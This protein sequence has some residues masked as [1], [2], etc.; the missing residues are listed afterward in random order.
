VAKIKIQGDTS[1]IKKSLLDL[2]K[3]VRGLG[4]SKVAIFDKQQTNFIKTEMGKA[5]DDLKQKLSAN[6]SELIK[7]VNE[8]KNAK[9]SVETEVASRKKIISLTKE[10]LRI[11][12]QISD[13]K[14]AS[15]DLTSTGMQPGTPKRPSLISGRLGKLASPMGL[16]GAAAMFAVGRG[17]SAHNKYSEGIPDRLKLMGRGAMDTDLK[18]PK[19]AAEAG[20]DAQD[21]RRGRLASMDTFGRQGATQ[22]AVI[23]RAEVERN[24]GLEQGTFQ[25]A[26]SQLR[27]QF[28]GE[29]AAREVTAMQA[30]LIASGITDE[31]GPYLET[32]AEMLKNLNENGFTFTDSAL[33]ALN[34]L[35][36]DPR[37]SAERAGKMLGGI[38]STIRGASGESSAFFQNVFNQAGIGGGS[39]GGIQAAMR[40]GGLFGADLSKAAI[41]DTDRRTFEQAG[42]GGRTGQKV[43]SSTVKVLDEMFGNDEEIN[44]LLKSSDKDKKQAGSSR[45]MQRLNFIMNTFGLESEQ[46][47]AEVN[48]LLGKLADPKTSK[49]ERGD[50]QKQIE[51]IQSGST[52]LGN[53]K[54]LNSTNEGILDATKN[55]SETLK[56]QL[57]GQLTPIFTAMSKSMANVDGGLSALLNTLGIQTPEEKMKEDI[58]KQGGMGGKLSEDQLKYIQA[59][60]ELKE[61]LYT[62]SIAKEGQL[63]GEVAERKQGIAEHDEKY[64]DSIVGKLPPIKLIQQKR[65]YDVAKGNLE[66]D[67]EQK[68]REQIDPEGFRKEQVSIKKQQESVDSQKSSDLAELAKIL[69]GQK[70]NAT[71]APDQS[72]LMSIFNEMNQ[73]LL[74]GN[75]ERRKVNSNLLKA[76]GVSAAGSKT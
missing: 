28:G 60:P 14:T 52:E 33:A 8:Q 35:T 42:I 5:L 71:P 11:Q 76:G 24:F 66:I 59:N 73:N 10:Q 64:G 50:I 7:Y 6:K 16:A 27:G 36:K 19:R 53:L 40:S 18:D 13:V 72:Q 22:E 46:Q 25:Q 26:G 55:V 45:R 70:Q 48:A 38:D 54:T 51:K 21:V 17:I 1:D 23:Q 62:K 63:K 15:S 2:A 67:R 29:G 4:K 31:I 9:N 3:D 43:A 65:K 41:S 57:G 49:K 34:T 30:S 69:T 32:S 74:Q 68:F 44:K 37:L 12:K 47:G 75:A 58:L 61:E 39:V 20:M 56:D